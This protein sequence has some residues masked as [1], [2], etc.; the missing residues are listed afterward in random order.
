MADFIMDPR[1]VADSAPLASLG[2]CEARLRLDARFPW[3]VLIPRK[4]GSRELE[5]LAAKDRARLMDEIVAAGAAVRAVGAALGRPVDKLNVG[6]LG[7]KVE[8]LHV[9][10]LGRR[11]DDP[12][13]PESAWGFPDPVDY[14]PAILDAARIAALP[15]FEGVL[16]A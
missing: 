3:I 7:N 6:A 5:H 12:A 13:W 11:P 4:P 14:A 10:V 1:L 15:A 2:L 9:H 16:R 8:Q